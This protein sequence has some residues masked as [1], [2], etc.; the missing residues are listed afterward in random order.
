M[1]VASGMVAQSAVVAANS[2]SIG[3]STGAAAIVLPAVRASGAPRSYQVIS[4]TVPDA[5]SRASRIAME[6]VPHGEF[7]ILGPHVR[8]IAGN[9]TTRIGVT[10]GI[11]ASALAGRLVAA[12]VRFSAPGIPV[13]IVPVDID[14]SLVR[15]LA[16]RPSTLPLNAQAGNDVIVPFEVVNSGNAKE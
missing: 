14:V 16:L 10:I 7:I 5:L 2:I 11:P 1:S 6:I 4:I 8:S 15:Q 12:D 9:G 13:I 3:D